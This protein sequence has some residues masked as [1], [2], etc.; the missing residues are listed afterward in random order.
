MLIADKNSLL[1]SLLKTL[2]FLI[3]RQNFT[4]EM[5]GKILQLSGKMLQLSGKYLQLSGKFLQL[6]GKILQLS[7][8]ILQLSG[9]F[10][11]L[12]GKILQLSGKIEQLSGKFFNC[13]KCLSEPIK[14][15]KT[16]K[17]SFIFE[18][19]EKK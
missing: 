14:T 1:Q 10:L 16:T 2:T 8:K 12:S 3:V 19:E 7:G 5:S 11:Q 17:T 18:G 13:E 6:S 9:K 15:S 4:N